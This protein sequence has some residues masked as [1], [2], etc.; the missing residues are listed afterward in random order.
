[1][2]LHE[3]PHPL[4]GVLLLELWVELTIFYGTDTVLFSFFGR[5]LPSGAVGVVYNIIRDRYSFI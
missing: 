5:G 3:G 4:V 1:V 2:E